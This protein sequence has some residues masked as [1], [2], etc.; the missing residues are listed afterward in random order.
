L[1]LAIANDIAK[2]HGGMLHLSKS[3]ALG[4]LRVDMMIAR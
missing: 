4:G 1:G 3:K 2:G